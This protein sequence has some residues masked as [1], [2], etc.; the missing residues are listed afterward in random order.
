MEAAHSIE[1]WEDCMQHCGAATAHYGVIGLGP[2][3]TL[4]SAVLSKA[5]QR[6]STVSLEPEKAAAL[7]EA[8]IR[9]RGAINLEGRVSRAFLSLRELI[10]ADP[11]VVLIT[12]KSCDSPALLDAVKA[13][14]PDPR[15]V[16]VSCQNGIDVEMQIVERFG[17]SRALRMVLN[18][19]CRLQSAIE[20]EVVFN[21]PSILSDVAAVPAEVRRSFARHLSGAG[22][23]VQTVENYQTDVFKKAILNSSMGSVSALTGCTMQGVLD[24]PG[25]RQVLKMMIEE[26]IAI[27]QRMG[28]DIGPGYVEEAF[29]YLARGGHHRPSMLEDL[30]RG[31]KTEND[32]HCGRLVF[33][34]ETFG[35]PAPVNRTMYALVRNREEAGRATR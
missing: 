6:V 22:F 30:E 8:P 23:P 33:Y 12:T 24:D 26:D 11:D 16:F 19:G 2:I 29:A 9:V 35:V 32:A 34:A 27:A 20:V 7:N 18:V 15:V 4:L 28:L 31:R 17:P 10:R 21:L 14:D 13:L 5:G 1:L 3:G 25:L